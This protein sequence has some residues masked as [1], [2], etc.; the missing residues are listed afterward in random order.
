MP[1]VPDATII[2]SGARR[3]VKAFGSTLITLDG[4]EAMTSTDTQEIKCSVCCGS[5]LND[6]RD[7]DKHDENGDV[8][9]PPTECQHCH[10][11]G[12]EP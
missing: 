1:P 4:K 6:L 3:L 11:T 12:K 9:Y 10:G 8:I 7:Y 2:R 5:G